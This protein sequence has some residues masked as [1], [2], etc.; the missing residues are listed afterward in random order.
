M[1]SWQEQ[2]KEDKLRKQTLKKR[3]FNR[4]SSKWRKRKERLESSRKRQDTLKE[5]NN[6]EKPEG[7]K[8]DND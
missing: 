5:A 3:Q 6:V 7:G 8:V 2:R 1:D 4:D